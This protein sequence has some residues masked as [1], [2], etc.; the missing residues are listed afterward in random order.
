MNSWT[1]KL[2]DSNLSFML[3]DNLKLTLFLFAA[4]IVFEW[5]VHSANLQSEKFIEQKERLELHIT[6]ATLKQERLK[7]MLMSE[8]DPAWIELTLMRVLGVIPEGT[9]KIY[10]ND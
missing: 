2:G 5:G 7:A 3:R 9:K 1:R 10:F 4:I 6:K 8:S